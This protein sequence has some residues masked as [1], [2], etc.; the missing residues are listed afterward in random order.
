MLLR[1]LQ[2]APSKYGSY[3]AGSGIGRESK[4]PFAALIFAGSGS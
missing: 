3:F 4:S 2:K 1:R